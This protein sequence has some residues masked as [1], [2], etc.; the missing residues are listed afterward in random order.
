MLLKVSLLSTLPAFSAIYRE[1]N[2]MPVDLNFDFTEMPIILQHPSF[3]QRLDRY[4]FHTASFFGTQCYAIR[5]AP[6]LDVC[7][8]K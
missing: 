8:Y 7:I 5:F 2:A 6:A 1:D 3:H 4:F